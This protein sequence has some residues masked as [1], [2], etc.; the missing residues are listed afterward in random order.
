M[1]IRSILLI[2]FVYIVQSNNLYSQRFQVTPDGMRDYDKIKNNYIIFNLKNRS[3]KIIYENTLRYVNKTYSDPPSM[4]KGNYRN[5]FISYKNVHK[6]FM[7]FTYNTRKV[8]ICIEYLIKIDIK[9]D[10][11]KFEIT[12]V[13]MYEQDIRER[14]YVFFKQKTFANIFYIYNRRGG[15][16][17]PQEKQIIENYFN[18][19]INTILHYINEYDKLSW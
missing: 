17:R 18:G 6:D 12:D 13:I 4:I 8:P 3:A 2:V 16:M 7:T 9:K 19:Q 15:L 1:E 14:Y 5:E 11:I 10:R